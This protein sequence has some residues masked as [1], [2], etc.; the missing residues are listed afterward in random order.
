MTGLAFPYGV[1]D[2]KGLEGIGKSRSLAGIAVTVVVGR[3]PD[4]GRRVPDVAASVPDRDISSLSDSFSKKLTNN[5][6]KLC[7]DN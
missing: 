7:N 5:S 4:G 2:A 1:E 3:V 6:E